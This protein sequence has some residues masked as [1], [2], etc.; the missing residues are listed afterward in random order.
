MGVLSSPVPVSR[1]YVQ[2]MASSVLEYSEYFNLHCS[3]NNGTKP[4]YSWLKGGKLLTNDSRL[5][6]SHNQK[7]L[8]ILRVL[9]SDDDIYAC[10]V[11]NPISSV[12]SLP[13]KLTVYSKWS[14][15]VRSTSQGR[16]ALL[17]LVVLL[18]KNWIWVY[19]YYPCNL[20]ENFE[21]MRRVP[22]KLTSYKKSCSS[23]TWP[24]HPK[25]INA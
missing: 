25:C 24:N 15:N 3:H 21:R 8:T 12:K 4:A 14:Y 17:I 22:V 5:M 16:L 23:L 9:M 11:E 13:V 18:C 10:L 1:P 6:M 20:T 7:V 2:M 19:K